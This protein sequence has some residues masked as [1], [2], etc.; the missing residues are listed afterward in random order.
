MTNLFWMVATST[1]AVELAAVLLLVALVVGWFPLVK[2]L[3]AIGAYVPAARLVS[4]ALLAAISFSI[5]FR[6]ADERDN[7]EKLRATLASRD[8]DLAIAV[9]SAADARKRLD[10]SEAAANAQWEADADYISKLVP[11]DLCSFDPGPPGGVRAR[12]AAGNAGAR[13]S[14]GS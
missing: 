12:A 8:R 1:L 3:P 6:T 5:G 4:I 2:Y 7:M 14:G 13:T 11:S 10:A 9:K